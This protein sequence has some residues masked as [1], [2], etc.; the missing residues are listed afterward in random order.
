MV[1]N[2]I[3]CFF[4]EPGNGPFAMEGMP[5]KEPING[6][7]VNWVKVRHFNLAGLLSNN[8]INATAFA[9]GVSE[10]N[11]MLSFEFEVS[12]HFWRFFLSQEHILSAVRPRH[13]KT[14]TLVRLAFKS[15][16]MHLPF[17]DCA[18]DSRSEK[19][20]RSQKE[21][22]DRLN[23]DW[24]GNPLSAYSID[25]TGSA[26]VLNGGSRLVG[27]VHYPPPCDGDDPMQENFTVLSSI[28]QQHREK[29]ARRHDK[30]DFIKCVLSL[31]SC[32][33]HNSLAHSSI[34]RR[35]QRYSVANCMERNRN[36]KVPALDLCWWQLA[37][38]NS[39]C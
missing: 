37:H 15:L 5:R 4:G 27:G 34:H 19:L 20:P 29:C 25:R 28:E 8:D 23:R 35:H 38:K 39:M 18:I 12:P 1:A 24:T 2:D 10:V 22:V 11:G 26:Y 14:R 13:A 33:H 30:S 36:E 16:E 32:S 17:D 7:E 21:K 3:D 9:I 6:N 31:W